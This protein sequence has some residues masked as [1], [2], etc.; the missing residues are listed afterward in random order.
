[1]YTLESG[2]SQIDGVIALNGYGIDSILGVTGPV[3]V[4]EY[5][6]TVKAGETTI[7]TLANTRQPTEPGADR[8]AFLSAF[9]VDVLDAMLGTPLQKMPALLTALQAATSQRNLMVWSKDSADE[10]FIAWAGWDGAVRA[11]PGDY[12]EALDANVAPAS[13][14]NLVTHRSLDLEVQ[15]DGAGNA[16]DSLALTWDNRINLAEGSALRSLPRVSTDG[17]LGNYLRVLTPSGSALQSVSGGRLVQLTGVEEISPEAGRTAYGLFLF[18]PPGLTSVTVS[19][20]SPHAVETDGKTGLYR[21]TVQKEDGRTAEP[22]NVSITLPHGAKV[23]D[24]SA[25]ILVNGGIATLDT[26]SGTDVQ[27]WVRYSL[28]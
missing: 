2:D 25:G 4:P 14:F 23:L 28:P 6:V 7:T 15:I 13:Y 3:A 19:W 8:K 26:T 17:L 1:L 22:L 9:G 20:V 27:V 16:H 12:V 5:G 18:E 10:A 21:L 24:T 11:D